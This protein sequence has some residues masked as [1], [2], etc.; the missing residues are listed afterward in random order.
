MPVSGVPALRNR[1]EKFSSSARFLTRC[2]MLEMRCS[3]QRVPPTMRVRE[4]LR[5]IP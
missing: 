5:L 4:W 3:R 2:S 1:K